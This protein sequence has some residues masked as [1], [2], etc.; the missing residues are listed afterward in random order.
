MLDVALM[1]TVFKAPGGFLLAYAGQYHTSKLFFSQCCALVSGLL[2]SLAATAAPNIPPRL[3]SYRL[4]QRSVPNF[5][6][7][8]GAIPLLMDLQVWV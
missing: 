7:F 4:E 1:L 3:T 2:A 6:S 5:G 8:Q